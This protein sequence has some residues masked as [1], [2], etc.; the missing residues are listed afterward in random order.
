MFLPLF[1]LPQLE[2]NQRR[3]KTVGTIHGRSHPSQFTSKPDLEQCFKKNIYVYELQENGTVAPIYQSFNHFEEELQL[4]LHNHHL[5]LITDFQR[6]AKKYTY[7]HCQKL[8][9]HRGDWK[10]RIAQESKGSVCGRYLYSAVQ[11]F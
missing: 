4:N 10:K 1:S 7:Q 5:S 3:L 9:D 11:F 8:F 2:E 6:Y